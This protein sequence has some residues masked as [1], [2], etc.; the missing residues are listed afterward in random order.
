MR[1]SAKESGYS[2]KPFSF[3]KLSVV[4]LGLGGVLFFAPQSRA[5]A[6]V[7]PDHFDGTDS[8][9]AAA[10]AKVPAA[11]A[12]SHSVPGTLQ[13]QNT[14]PASPVLQPVAAREVTAPSRSNA[15]A[16]KKRKPAKSDN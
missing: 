1:S 4:L 14:K 12:K 9:A 16:N 15:T 3:N 2:M 13:A 11:Q 5:Q 7:A 6:D 10:V 8:W